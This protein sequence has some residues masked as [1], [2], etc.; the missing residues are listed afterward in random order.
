MRRESIQTLLLAAT[1]L[2][3]VVIMILTAVLVL[4]GG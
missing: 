4:N 3:T 2:C 1:A